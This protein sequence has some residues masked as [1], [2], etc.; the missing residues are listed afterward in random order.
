MSFIAKTEENYLVLLPAKP[1]EFV[2]LYDQCMLRPQSYI[3][4]RGFRRN[5][6]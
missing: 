2:G 1:M 6:L 5:F 4:I 3:L